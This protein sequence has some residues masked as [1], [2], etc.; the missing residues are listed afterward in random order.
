MGKKLAIDEARKILDA[1]QMDLDLEHDFE[2]ALP[3]ENL[4]NNIRCADALFTTWPSADA[5][6]GNPP[7]QSKNKM[8]QEYGRKYLN[9]LRKTYP[10]IPGRADYC[11]YWFRRAH[12]ALTQDGRA[13]LVGTNTIRQNYSREGGLDYIVSHG[14]TIIDAVSNQEWSGDAAV[15]VSIVNWVKGDQ[16]GLKR[17]RIQDIEKP[18]KPWRYQDVPTINSSLSFDTD[19]SMANVLIVNSIAPICFQGQTHGHEGFLLSPND[20]AAMTQE[21]EKNAEVIIPFLGAEELLSTFPPSPKRWVIDFG[22]RTVT[23]AAAYAS[24]F[25]RIKNL[26][27]PDREAAAQEE[28]RRNQ[29]ALAVNPRATLNHHHRNFL[30]RWWRLSYGRED[31][32]NVIGLISRYVVC[33]RVTK[34][35]IFAFVSSKIHPNDSLAV[36]ALADDYSFGVLQSR[37][38]WDWFVAKCSTLTERFRYTSNTVF[39]TFPWPQSPTEKDVRSVAAAAVALRHKRE[40]IM[41]ANGWSLRDLYASMELPGEH[42]LRDAQEALDQSV[43]KAYGMGPSATVLAFLLELNLEVS[44][45]VKQK[46]TVVGPGLAALG[47]DFAKLAQDLTTTD[48]VGA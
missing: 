31:L 23:Q 35:P 8:Q 6:I 24:P 25:A 45:R 29:E 46:E 11:V 40:E 17:L 44:S 18:G 42:P 36:F 7:Y 27:L 32:L 48:C 30:A 38:H 33:S 19:V 2:R 4:D 14:G 12:D 10:G 15:S 21:S 9:E 22:T 1:T 47:G 3:M 34:R 28:Q 5:I 39:D 43:S 26:V 37:H 16:K 41:S 20:A 13:G